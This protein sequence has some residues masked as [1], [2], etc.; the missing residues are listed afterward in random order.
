MSASRSLGCVCATAVLL[1]GG[2]IAADSGAREEWGGRVGQ[3]QA[4]ES[5]EIVL[6]AVV[7]LPK[8]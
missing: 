6:T 4:P 1:A 5:D 3:L 8:R 7:D 2:A